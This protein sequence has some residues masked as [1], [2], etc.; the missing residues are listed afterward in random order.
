MHL[1]ISPTLL[2]PLL[3]GLALSLFSWGKYALY[4]FRLL[5]TWVHECCHCV[6]ALLVGGQ[7]SRITLAP[8]TSGLTHFRL[9]VGRLRQGVVAS[10][11]Y[12]GSS[13][14]GCTLCWLSQR[15]WASPSALLLS[16]GILILFTLLVW[17]RGVFGFLVVATL[18]ASLIGLSRLPARA[19]LEWIVTFIALQ[20]ATQALFDL[21]MLFSLE[22][23]SRSD[24]HTMSKLF[25]LPAGFWATLW[26]GASSALTFW[27]LRQAG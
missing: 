13:G 22:A 15:H 17:V 20:I 6:A 9:P 7:V 3:G 18:G 21:R 23:R 4:P 10:A 24:A 25:Y 12:L 11:G 27:T 5:T 8:D 1:P 14:V 16:L 2:I 19:H 26:I